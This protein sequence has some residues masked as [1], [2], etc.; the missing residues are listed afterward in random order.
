MTIRTEWRI[1]KRE[2]GQGKANEGNEEEE[3]E[4]EG[5]EED[6]LTNQSLGAANERSLRARRM[7]GTRE[8]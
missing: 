5:E 3:S 4:S 2:G 7:N 1:R 8:Y 6:Q